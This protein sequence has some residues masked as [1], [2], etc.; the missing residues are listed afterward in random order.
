MASLLLT[1]GHMKGVSIIFWCVL[2]FGFVVAFGSYIGVLA[3]KSEWMRSVFIN[4]IRHDTISAFVRRLMLGAGG[5]AV[6]GTL[7]FVRDRKSG[8][9]P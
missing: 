4:D 5:G 1:L 7:L 6:I 8:D 2:I 3:P 9:D